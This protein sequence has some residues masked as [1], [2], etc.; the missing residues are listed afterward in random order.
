MTTAHKVFLNRR[1]LVLVEHALVEYVVKHYEDSFELR[2]FFNIFLERGDVFFF[3]IRA[4]VFVSLNTFDTRGNLG[5]L[6]FDFIA[7]LNRLLLLLCYFFE[8]T[9]VVLRDESF[10]RKMHSG[11]YLVGFQ[12]GR[13]YINLVKL[14]L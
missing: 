11:P 1:N 13:E 5:V 8:L 9:R 2:E 14:L 3:L 7:F 6:R 12:T 10:F 4:H